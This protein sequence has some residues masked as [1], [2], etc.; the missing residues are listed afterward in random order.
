MTK[1]KQMT[2]KELTQSVE[3]RDEELDGVSGGLISVVYI[4]ALKG[5]KYRLARI[6]TQA[7][8][9]FDKQ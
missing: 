2:E 9:D 3:L 6:T 1:Q 7:E 8:N 4:A 5:P